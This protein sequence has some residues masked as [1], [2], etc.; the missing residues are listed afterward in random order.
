MKKP[1]ASSFLGMLLV[2]FGC[3][4]TENRENVDNTVEDWAGKRTWNAAIK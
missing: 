1:T 2:V 4:G 3:E